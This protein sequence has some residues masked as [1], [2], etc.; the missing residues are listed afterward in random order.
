[1]NSISDIEKVTN[2]PQH[3]IKELGVVTK[4]LSLFSKKIFA[5]SNIASKAIILLEKDGILDQQ[6]IENLNKKYQDMRETIKSIEALE[7]KLQHQMTSINTYTTTIS[8]KDMSELP[9]IFNQTHKKWLPLNALLATES[10]ENDLIESS[11]KIN[12]SES[13]DKLKFFLTNYKVILKNHHEYIFANHLPKSFYEKLFRILGRTDEMW[14]SALEEKNKSKRLKNLEDISKTLTQLNELIDKT[15]KTDR[16]YYIRRIFE[17]NY[18]IQNIPNT[19]QTLNAS[20][21]TKKEIIEIPIHGHHIFREVYS[22]SKK[23]TKKKSSNAFM[24]FTSRELYLLFKEFNIKKSQVIIINLI[25]D[26]FI[27]WECK[28][29]HEEKNHLDDSLIKS[30]FEDLNKPKKPSS[31]AKKRNIQT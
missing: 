13:S 16:S 26:Y 17:F 27:A 3:L 9:Q 23:I 10:L 25:N 11:Q 8:R 7:Q 15:N 5:K 2:L 1:M 14:S 24:Q 22:D 20:I 31:Y 18:F 30:F 12:L 4:K 19:I 28:Q 6:T 21:K 29:R